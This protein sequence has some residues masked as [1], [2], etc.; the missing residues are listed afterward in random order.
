MTRRATLLASALTLSGLYHPAGAANV[1]VPEERIYVLHSKAVGTCPSLDWH[2]AATPDGTL[3]GLIAWDNLKSI[4]KATG[5]VDRQNR[6]FSM[7][8]VVIGAEERKAAIDGQV[9]KDGW[10]IANVR[11]DHINCSAIAVPIY[12]GPPGSK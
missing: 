1:R 9:R 6:T 7:T 5:R 10:L 11:G 4:A 12:A 8:A 2:I 3:S